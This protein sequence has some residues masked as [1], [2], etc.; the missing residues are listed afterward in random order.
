M[1]V[2]EYYTHWDVGMKAIHD[3]LHTEPIKSLPHEGKM[4]IVEW[5]WDTVD[6]M[7]PKYRDYV[8]DMMQ[9]QAAEKFLEGMEVQRELDNR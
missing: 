3:L 7:L 1:Q 5:F 4:V 2:K 8:I 6:L 9:Q